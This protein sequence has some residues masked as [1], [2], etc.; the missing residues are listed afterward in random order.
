[1][2]L[3]CLLSQL[4][5][6]QLFTPPSFQVGPSAPQSQKLHQQLFWRWFSNVECITLQLNSLIARWDRLMSRPLWPMARSGTSW[7]GRR[8]RE[9]SSGERETG[10]SLHGRRETLCWGEV[11]P[12]YEGSLQFSLI[13]FRGKVMLWPTAIVLRIFL[14]TCCAGSILHYWFSLCLNELWIVIKPMWNNK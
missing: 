5:R 11:W 1:M 3:N 10:G 4:H 6:F 14:A 7:F 12:R 9:D 2:V 13:H 8:L